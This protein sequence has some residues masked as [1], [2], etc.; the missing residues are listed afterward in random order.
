MY[1]SLLGLF[2]IWVAC[3]HD[4]KIDKKNKEAADPGRELTHEEDME[5]RRRL[6]YWDE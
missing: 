3:T 1:I 6:D 4:A 2:C 5:I